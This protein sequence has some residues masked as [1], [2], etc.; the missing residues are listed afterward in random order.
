M[1]HRF[2]ES[3]IG[4]HKIFDDHI[5]SHKMNIDNVFISFKNTVSI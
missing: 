3:K 5:G 4:G 1:G 2:L